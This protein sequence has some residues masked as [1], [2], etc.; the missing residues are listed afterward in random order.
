MKLSVSNIA[1]PAYDHARYFPRLEEMS[2]EGVEVAPSRVWRET[3]TALKSVEVTKYRK[4]VEN[5]GL[6]VVGL[7]SL[8]FDHPELGLFKGSEISRLTLDYL[9]HLSG[10]CR[11]LGG[12]TI[13]FGSPP[14]RR[15]GNLSLIEAE[16]EV[17]DFFGTLCSQISHHGTCFCLEPLAANESDFV[18][19]A[20]DAI[21]MANAVNDQAFQVQ[22][23][24]K[25]L[26]AAGE[27]NQ[28]IFS[29]AGLKLVHYHV[30]EPD[31]GVL[32][33]GV[34]DHEEIAALLRSVNYDGFV[35]LE[36]RML[37]VNEPLNAIRISVAIMK[38][39]YS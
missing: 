33:S 16:A 2:F 24:A 23:D 37:D 30:N 4:S 7:H 20:R 1:L 38:E 8:F 27:V 26:T 10:V 35:S 22:F 36:Q 6:T 29:Q 17:I 14:A 18:N 28:E 21:R 3:W 9:V 11:D 34:V 15:R 19:S 31:L 12:K 5:A 32:S 13:V 25:A 39:F